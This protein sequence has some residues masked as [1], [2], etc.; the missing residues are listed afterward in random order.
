MFLNGSNSITSD[1]NLN[2]DRFWNGT[3]YIFILK[4]KWHSFAVL[5]VIFIL[6]YL[7]TLK[8]HYTYQIHEIAEFSGSDFVMGEEKAHGKQCQIGKT[9]LH[10]S[11]YICRCLISNNFLR[12]KQ[13]ATDRISKPRSFS[14]CLLGAVLRKWGERWV[15]ESLSFLFYVFVDR[16]RELLPFVSS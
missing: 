1:I 2:L 3:I 13:K 4:C 7:S 15:R 16:I 9:H 10:I 12:H 5:Q 6:I 8:F 14:R 11:V